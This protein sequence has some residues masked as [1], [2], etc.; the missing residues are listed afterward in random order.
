MRVLRLLAAALLAAAL[1]GAAF[2]QD[3]RRGADLAAH[4]CV[5]CHG[6][7]GRSQTQG[8]PSL[9][10]QQTEFITLQL[11]L[12]REGIRQ[13]PAMTPFAANLPDRDIED[14]AAFFASLPAGPPD[15]REPRDAAR[16][17]AGQA[18]S[19]PRNCA[20]CHMPNYAGR[21]QVPR[22]TGQREDFLAQTLKDYRDGRRI[23]A[24]PQMNGAVAGLSDADLIALAHYLAQHD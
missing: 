24:D 9:A 2:A 7:D 14:L 22:L 17:A 10:G 6:A 5:N 8:V 16:F 21:N 1:P 15:D 13:V 20:V 23:G 11:I 19:G 12:F 3:A 4:L 18:L